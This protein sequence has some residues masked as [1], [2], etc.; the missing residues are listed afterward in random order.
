MTLVYAFYALI[1]VSVAIYVAGRLM[2]SVWDRWDLVPWLTRRMQSVI[3]GADT[4]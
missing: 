4:R 3:R 1:G 2:S